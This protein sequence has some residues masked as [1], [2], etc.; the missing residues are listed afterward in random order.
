MRSLGGE[1]LEEQGAHRTFQ[2]DMVLGN[3]V[4]GGGDDLHADKAEMLEQGRQVG[5]IAR[6]AIQRLGQ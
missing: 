1:V 2:A 6:Q 3:F 5:L 4:L